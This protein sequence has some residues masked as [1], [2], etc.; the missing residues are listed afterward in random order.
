VSPTRGGEADKF[1]NRYEGRWTVAALLRILVGHATSIIIEQRGEAGKGVEFVLTRSGAAVEAHQVKRQR[2]NQNNW[3][4]RNLRDDE[5]LKAAAEQVELGREFWFVSTIP[6]RDLDELADR[7][8]RSDGLPAFVDALG[9]TLGEKF[10]FLAKQW[11]TED[12][13]FAILQKVHVRW[14]DERH[15]VDTNAGLAELLLA[16]AHGRASAVTLGDLAWDNLG[17]TLDAAAIEAGIGEYGLARA[18]LA[19]PQTTTAVA[20][21]LAFWSQSVARELLQ[22]VIARTEADEVVERLRASANGVLL[23]SGNAGDGKSA[24]LHQAVTTLAAEWPV[25]ALRLDQIDAFSST[26]ELGVDRLGLPASPAAALAAV[27]EAGDCLLV[28]D[29]LDAVSLASG[30]MPTSF[31]HIVA[32]IREAEA[33]DRMRVL[34]ACRQFDIDNDYRVRDLVAEK[35]PAEQMSIGPLT[36]EQVAAA[37][38]AMGLDSSALSPAQKELLRTPLHLVLLKAVADEPEALTFSTVK[39]LMDAFYDRKRRDSDAHAGDRIRFGETINTLVE[40]MS[41]NQ[42]LYAPAAVLDVRD[43]QRD[44]D[45]MASEHV[46]VRDG[47]RLRFF[48]EAFF[49]YAFARSWLVRDETLV[50]FLLS[51][52][53]ELFRRAQVRA[54]LIHLRADEPERFVAEVDA[55]LGEAGVR[56]HIKEVV[57]ALLRAIERPTAAEWRLVERHIAAAPAFVER[58][59]SMLRTAGWFDRLD[60]AR[61]I[62]GWLRE[63]GERFGRAIDVMVSVSKDR[64]ARLAAL[65]AGVRSDPRY[66]GALRH[67]SFYVDLHSSREMFELVLD[68]VRDGLFE[69]GAH[70]LFMSAHAL[71]TDQPR[72]ACELLQAW[73]VER[74]DPYALDAGGKIAAL[75]GRDHGAEEII[76]GAAEKAPADFASFAVPYLLGAM[77]ATRNDDR[78][79]R[80][81]RHF[82]FR[83]YN[84]RHYDLDEALIYGARDALRGMVT[85]G[86]HAEAR[87]LLEALAADEHDA[88]QWL[89][90]QALAAD[91]PTY[92]NWAVELLGQGEHRLLSGYTCDPFWTARE[93]VVTIAPHLSDEQAATLEKFFMGMSPP[94]ESR[95]PGRASWVFLTALPEERLSEHGRRRVLELRRLFG[96]EPNPPTGIIVGHVTAPIPQEAAAKMSDEQWLKAIARHSSDDTNYRQLTGGAYEQAM[97]LEEETKTDPTRFAALVLRF[98]RETH[99]AYASAVLRGL[100]E[101]EDVDPRAIFD[102]MRYVA[103]MEIGE[104]DRALVNALRR[105]L[106]ADIPDDIIQLL[107]NRAL[108]SQDPDHE[109]WQEDA[110][111]GQNYYNGDPF[112]NGMNSVRGGA[113]LTL[114]DLLVHDTDGRRTKLISTSFEAL[115]SD[116]SIAVRSCVAHLLAAALRHARPEAVAAFEKLIDAP[117]ELLGTGPVESLIVYIGFGESALVEPVIARM[118]ASTVEPTREA[119]GRLAAFAAL[120]LELG[121]LLDEARTSD[122]AIRRGAAGT[123]AHRL[124]ITSDVE[125]AETALRDFFHDENDK[126]RDQAA[127]V[128]GALRNRPLAPHRELIEDLI[129]SQ[130]FE[131]ALPQLLIT[132]EHATEPVDELVIVTARRF[133]ELYRGQMHNIATRAAGDAKEIGELTLRGYAQAPD[134]AARG[135]ALDLIDELLAEAAYNFSQ[136]IDEAER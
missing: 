6:C 3:T 41:D 51:G 102:V 77:A 123:C 22:P 12:H 63:D 81:D 23:V 91:G 84:A 100:S 87:P 33:F 55:L 57:V 110:G 58:L 8:R 16:G 64:P 74:T 5:V 24:V 14:P 36:S 32:V 49:D 67:V 85:G 118:L 109:A 78:R 13:A 21:T 42:R 75:E 70:D 131:E 101:A 80:R 107:L 9:K 105:Q 61:A 50:A 96:D 99:P 68:G 56:F 126:V 66:G 132:L 88:A 30:R 38:N 94:W 43:L 37:V 46:L 26:H 119:G 79:P 4:L 125:R 44:G 90:Y 34:L 60:A 19:T 106:D 116:P 108:K 92:V 71:G 97:V 134:A 89:L 112:S 98:N 135:R 10:G 72:W 17:K 120:E 28:I 31:E 122:V 2:G 124:P 93:L 1:G 35:G 82:G 130:A 113:A 83:T 53:Q 69:T 59:W 47:P 76:A 111:G 103:R 62:E 73:F 15:L 95:P 65:L 114:G 40:S 86:A 7:A 136:L 45:V 133:V 127:E 18:Q 128:A 20:D 29:Q 39:G 115:A 104:T 117:D 48:H 129:V 11:G 52:E 121:H 27:A 25:L 54:V